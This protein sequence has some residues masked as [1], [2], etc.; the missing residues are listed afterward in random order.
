VISLD[1][2]EDE[3]GIVVEDELEDGEMAPSPPSQQIV[4]QVEEITADIPPPSSPQPQQQ[5]EQSVPTTPPPGNH[6]SSES[7]LVTANTPSTPFSLNSI[8]VEQC[9]PIPNRF[10]ISDFVDDEDDDDEGDDD[11]DEGDDDDV[12]NDSAASPVGDDDGAGENVGDG[13][14]SSSATTTPVSASKRPRRRFMVSDPSVNPT[15]PTPDQWAKNVSEHMDFEN[16][17]NTEG[18]FSKIKEIAMKRKLLVKDKKKR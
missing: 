7:P 12:N 17:P 6:I 10:D 2:E 9:T 16:L 11:E 14:A 8:S 15:M 1:E 3:D 13:D 4:D 5:R 18:R